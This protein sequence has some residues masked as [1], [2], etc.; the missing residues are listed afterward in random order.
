MSKHKK[1]F[2][3]DSLDVRM[4]LSLSLSVQPKERAGEK[5]KI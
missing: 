2:L 3:T 5:M 4:D 1:K